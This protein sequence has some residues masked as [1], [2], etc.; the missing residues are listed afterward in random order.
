MMFIKHV[1]ALS[2][3]ALALAAPQASSLS[4][5]T[6]S[7]VSIVNGGDGGDSVNIN[8]NTIS[9]KYNRR[10]LQVRVLSRI[11]EEAQPLKE[12]S[13]C[14]RLGRTA[15]D[16]M[17]PSRREA[18]SLKGEANTS[19]QALFCCPCAGTHT[20]IKVSI[21]IVTE[22]LIHIITFISTEGT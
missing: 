7:N 5:L 18:V 3:A 17:R 19:V 2:F 15:V 11:S 6:Q 12:T 10:S 8:N 22:I 20:H 13:P 16:Q 21:W 14:V 1:L 4:N 9:N